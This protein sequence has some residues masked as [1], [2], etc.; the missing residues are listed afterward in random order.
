MKEFELKINSITEVEKTANAFVQLLKDNNI[1]SKCFAFYGS[2]GAG[3][4]TFIKALCKELGVIDVVT[5]PTFALIN[6]Y[7]TMN[8]Q[9]IYHFDFY[10]IN[11]LSEVFDFGYQEYF[12]SESY[13]F[14]EWPEKITDLLPPDF[15]KIEIT[16][17]ERDTRNI[18]ICISE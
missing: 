16:E 9:N 15:L 3:K 1:N 18:K 7:Q 4:T 10:R 14:I 2:M 13:C 8:G 11:A 17:Q 5:S 6:E 12:F